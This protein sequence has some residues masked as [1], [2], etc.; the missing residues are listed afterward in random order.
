MAVLVAFEPVM[1]VG[2]HL[3]KSAWRQRRGGTEAASISCVEAKQRK[4]HDEE[5]QR[6]GN[7][8]NFAK[9]ADEPKVDPAVARIARSK[10]QRLTNEAR[11]IS[12][13]ALPA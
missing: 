3:H 5:Y 4:G 10:P 6:R 1:Q 8:I 2:K 13:P 11:E 12:R 7:Q 9:T